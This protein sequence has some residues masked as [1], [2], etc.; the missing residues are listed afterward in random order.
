MKGQKAYSL[1]KSIHEK[2]YQYPNELSETAK[3]ELY[4]E[5]FKLVRKS[6]YLGHLE[7]Q[8]DMAQQYESMSFL[9]VQNPIY[10]PKKR[11]FWYS[12][13]CS[14]G[15]SDAC[16]NLASIY[17]LGEGCEQNLDLALR[18]YEK[19]AKL[20]SINGKKNYE[21]MLRDMAKG[22]RYQTLLQSLRSFLQ[23][24]SQDNGKISN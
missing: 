11:I 12:K 22:G 16:N 2:F 14:K 21:I 1:A 5:Y 6:A 4:N 13:A 15:H 17:E 7:A 24:H 23:K 9:G 8:Y 18:L 3:K 19:S 20:G 10:N